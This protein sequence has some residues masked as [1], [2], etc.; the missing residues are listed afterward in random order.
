MAII[1][2]NQTIKPANLAAEEGVRSLGSLTRFLQEA[3]VQTAPCDVQNAA[4]ALGIRVVYEPMDDDMSGF[5][6]RRGGRWVAGINAYHHPVRQRFTLAH[7]L[8]HYVLHR[9]EQERFEDR[10]YARRRNDHSKMEREAD[11]F[12]ASLLMPEVRVRKA[13]ES[14]V[15][16]LNDLARQFDVSSLAMRYRLENLGYRLG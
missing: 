13:I 3:G 1:K 15:K 16:N 2:L 4:R 10:T 14:G 8:A 11:A 7:E 12:A 6:E 9:S 5:L